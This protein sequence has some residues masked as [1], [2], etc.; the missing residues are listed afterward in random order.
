[1]AKIKNVLKSQ[2]FIKDALKT[3]SL[4]PKIQITANY[5]PQFLKLRYIDGLQTKPSDAM[6]Y[7][8]Y[9]E[10]HLLGATRDGKEP[11]IPYIGVKDQRPTKSAHINVMSEYIFSKHPEAVIQGTGKRIDFKPK[12][13]ASLPELISYIESNNYY[14]PEK[15]KKNDLLAF[16]ETMPEDLGAPE[17][18]KEDYFAYIETMPEDLSIG[19]KSTQ[20]EI[21]DLVVSNAK[22][23]L[24]R[25]GLDVEKGQKQLR[26]ETDTEVGH[27]DWFYKDLQDLTKDAIYDVKFTQTKIDDW[28][29][30]WFNADEKDEAK[31]QA[32]HYIHLHYKLH[33]VFVPFYFLIFGQDGWVRVLKYE[34]TKDAYNMHLV[35][36]DDA[37]TWLKEFTR[38][39]WKARPEYNRCLKCDFNEA[40]K[41]RSTLPEVEIITM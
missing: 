11:K 27:L 31:L 2:S 38:T 37:D 40:C 3:R 1:M 14:L 4:D 7:G 17:V 32:V 18:T 25:M 13:S 9:F 36:L 5:C 6:L 19:K 34:L 15:Q 10:W 20:E 41:F 29:N 26:L 22:K 33:K 39:K 16:I 28:R 23:L 35:L 8:Q 24:L 12:K 21:L 30:G